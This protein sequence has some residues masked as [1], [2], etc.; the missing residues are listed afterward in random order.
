M[1][2]F[3][4]PAGGFMLL[5]P[6]PG[7]CQVCAV[8]HKPDEAHDATSLFYQTRFNMRYK[9][10][11]TWADAIAH[12]APD[13]RAMWE[14]EIRRATEFTRPPAGVE[15]IAELTTGELK[16]SDPLAAAVVRKEGGAS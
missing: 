4:K 8:D 2:E 6:A 7:K 1:A 10:Q 3:V 15:P 11:G 5:P 16:T 13:R 12:L 9:R 14:A